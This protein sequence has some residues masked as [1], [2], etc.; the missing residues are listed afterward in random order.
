MVLLKVFRVEISFSSVF[1]CLNFL[2]ISH[3]LL[4]C[5]LLFIWLIVLI[6]IHYSIAY[7]TSLIWLNFWMIFLFI[8]WIVIV[9]HMLRF[10][11]K[12]IRLR[13][14]IVFLYNLLVIFSIFINFL[15]LRSFCSFHWVVFYL[16]NVNNLKIVLFSWDL[17]FIL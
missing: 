14:L 6:R 7:Y 8:L 16:R 15:S 10:N 11:L 5:V 3:F 4:L 13:I 17:T 2:I 1:S 12:W 9:R